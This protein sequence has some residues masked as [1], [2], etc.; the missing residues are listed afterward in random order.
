MLS[1]LCNPIYVPLTIKD[2][3]SRN[4]ENTNDIID[5]AKNRL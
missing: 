4:T 3:M 2:T 1:I 5:A